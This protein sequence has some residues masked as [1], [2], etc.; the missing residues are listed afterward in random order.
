MTSAPALF[1]LHG[2]VAIVTGG[3]T[4]LGRQM[5]L[6]LAEAGARVVVV[7]RRLERCQSTADAIEALGGQALALAVDVTDVEQTLEMARG[8]LDAFGRIDVLVNNAGGHRHHPVVSQ[9]LDEWRAV[10]DVYVTGAFLCAQAVGPHF[11]AQRRGR[12]INV[13]SVYGVVGRDGSLYAGDYLGQRTPWLESLPYSASKGG[14]LSL[15]RDLA[16]NWGRYGITVNAISPGMFGALDDEGK[17]PPSDVYPR[18]IERTPLRRLGEA[19]DLKGTVVFLAS[20][21]S[22][23]VTGHNL[24][25]DGGWTIW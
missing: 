9:P 7:G 5:A 3:G 12:I 4:G 14:Q 10:L 13:A 1:D 25:V 23:Y 22:A 11:I 18:L 17:R 19:D 24:I 6:G 16:G 20:D 15:T 2:R 8:T 21:A